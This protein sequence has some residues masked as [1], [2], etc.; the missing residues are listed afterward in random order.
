MQPLACYQLRQLHKRGY[1]NP[2]DLFARDWHECNFALMNAKNTDT[3]AYI[4]RKWGE[5]KM[6]P[7]QI[8]YGFNFIAQHDL[9]RSPDFWDLIVPMVKKQIKTLDR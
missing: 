3:F 6:T 1:S 7:E 8:M 9:E 2:D 5:D 4:Y